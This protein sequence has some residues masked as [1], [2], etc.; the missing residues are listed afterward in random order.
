MFLMVKQDRLKWSNRNDNGWSNKTDER[1]SNR[2]GI[3]GQTDRFFHINRIIDKIL[4]KKQ[5]KRD[6]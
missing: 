6:K 3:K 4:I 5:G 2:N 1:W